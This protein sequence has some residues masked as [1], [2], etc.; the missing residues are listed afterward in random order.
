MAS[1]LWRLAG[2]FAGSRV[3]ETVVEQL[4]D[5]V[6]TKTTAPPPGPGPERA[7]L[8]MLETVV[9]EH[10]DKLA[11]IAHGLE[12]LGQELR[13]LIARAAVTFWL[14]ILA[15]GLSLVSIVLLLRR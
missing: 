14:A 1:I 8:E 10:D 12:T 11:A 13:P 15:S 2:I 4:I 5:L 9:R 7:R 6:K 3:A